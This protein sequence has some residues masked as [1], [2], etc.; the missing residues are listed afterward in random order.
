MGVGDG[1]AVGEVVPA[2]GAGLVA[3]GVASVGV[4]DGTAVVAT[5]SD[6]EH[7]VNS[8]AMTAASFLRTRVSLDGASG[9]P[10]AASGRTCDMCSR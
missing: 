3:A 9:A 5:E 4:G 8:T 6:D 7:A 1:R 10:Y 2:V